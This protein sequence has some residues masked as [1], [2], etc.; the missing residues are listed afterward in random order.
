VDEQSWDPFSQVGTVDCLACG[1]R[2]ARSQERCSECGAELPGAEEEEVPLSLLE[3]GERRPVKGKVP[4]EQAKNLLKLQAAREGALGGHMSPEE[5]GRLVDEVLQIVQVG[6]ELFKSQPVRSK[7]AQLPPDQAE[8]VRRTQAETEAYLAGVQ[9][10]KAW[11]ASRDPADAEQG[12][13]QAEAALVAMD[14]IQDQALEKAV[15]DYP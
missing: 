12:Y 9:R 15:T 13:R 4:L 8:L 3:G 6:V 7:V 10:M 14:K 11:L 1:A 5:Y 2:N